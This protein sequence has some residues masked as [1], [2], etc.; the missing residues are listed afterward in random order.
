MAASNTPPTRRSMVALVLLIALLTVLT[1]GRSN[2]SSNGTVGLPRLAT[3]TR[4]T[5]SWLLLRYAGVASVSSSRH[6]L[7]LDVGLR[8]SEA[9]FAAGHLAVHGRPAERVRWSAA[10]IPRDAVAEDLL[11]TAVDAALPPRPINCAAIL[12]ARRVVS[13]LPRGSR[14]RGRLTAKLRQHAL[15]PEARC[16]RH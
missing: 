13:T 8:S 12:E 2:P 1:V 9:R 6:L 15:L 16:P 5:A 3:K 4:W 10:L 11:L 7:E 14:L